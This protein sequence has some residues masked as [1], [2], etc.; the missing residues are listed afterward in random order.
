MF[1]DAK[2][3][4][5]LLIYH[6]YSA[7]CVKSL[8]LAPNVDYISWG[9]KVFFNCYFTVVKKMWINSN[10]RD[11]C[12]QVVNKLASIHQIVH[13]IHN[14]KI[15]LCKNIPFCLRKLLSIRE[16]RLEGV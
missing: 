4:E 7:Y 12:N 16:Q 1:L 6:L 14:F 15:T 10:I 13:S 5:V 11:Y 9:I 3:T 2:G 8:G